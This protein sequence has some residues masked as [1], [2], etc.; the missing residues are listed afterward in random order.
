MIDNIDYTILKCLN[1]ADDAFWKKRAHQEIQECHD[2]LPITDNVSLQTIG[3]RIDALHDEGYVENTIVSPEDVPRDLIIGYSITEQGSTMLNVKRESL[4]KELVQTEL[5]SDSDAGSVGQQALAELTNNEFGLTDHAHETANSY[6][7]DELL[8]L[9]G[10]YFLRKQASHVFGDEDV[11]QFRNV[12][13]EQK[14]P[15]TVL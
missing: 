10:T 11:K 1:D 14:K 13:L 12:I 7:R 2:V 8:I 4:L 9:L 3:R 5:F 15:S 6:S